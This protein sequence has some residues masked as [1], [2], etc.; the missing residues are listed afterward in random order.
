M[1]LRISSLKNA[2]MSFLSMIIL[3]ITNLILIRYI[4][5]EYGS[6]SNGIYATV[7]QTISILTLLEAGFALSINVALFKP[8]AENREKEFK[9]IVKAASN[10]FY[11]VSILVLIIGLLFSIIYPMFIKTS[12]EINE[13]RWIYIF[14]IIP[15][16]MNYGFVTKYRIMLQVKQKEYIINSINAVFL[17]ITFLFNM[18]VIFYGGSLKMLVISSFIANIIKFFVLYLV[19]KRNYKGF[20]T[21]GISPNYKLIKGTGDV[22]IQK[23]TSIFYTVIPIF[24]ISISVGTA[25]LSVYVVYSA[26]FGI[27][28]Q[29]AYTFV[30]APQ[31]AF[32]LKLSKGNEGNLVSQFKIYQLIVS[33]V[34]TVL[35][36]PTYLLFYPFIELYTQ[37]SG[38]IDYINEQMLVLFIIIT[39]LEILHLP[40]GNI[41]NLNGDFKISRN[42]Q[43]VAISFMIIFSV[44]G[45]SLHSIE[46][47]LMG[48]LVCNI[49][50]FF[51][52]IYYCYKKILKIEF[53]FLFKIVF[54]YS[55]FAILTSL[56]FNFYIEKDFIVSYFE[57]AL[58]GLFISLISIILMV[59]I[60][61]IFFREII[62]LNFR[63]TF[64]KNKYLRRWLI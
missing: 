48:K 5:I 27:V 41:M 39:V 45:S 57:F 2:L 53:A 32:G 43:L 28:K 58:H 40:S 37:G 1:N 29:I 56:I 6:D 14:S 9:S 23:L 64:C 59:V 10:I 11:I 12:V 22:F 7:S 55:L 47:I 62:L 50:L 54:I 25:L 34:L 19:Y 44:L 13:I 21:I 61:F 52:E 31:Q 3:A 35:L 51:S 18:I 36:I 8:F 16:A 42:I 46:G 49:I 26:V 17:L 4:L 30:N 20:N 33:L 24:F 63:D 15:M 60:S 38:G